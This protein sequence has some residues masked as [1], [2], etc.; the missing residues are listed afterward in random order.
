M[1]TTFTGAQA[2]GFRLRRQHLQPSKQIPRARCPDTV[3][4]ICRDTAGIQAQVMSAAEMSI[5]TR[6]RTITRD[7]IRAALWTR[8][9][10][11]KTSAMRFTLHLVPA[12]DFATYIAA[13]KP[14]AYGIINRVFT[15]LSARPD[16][17]QA[18]IQSVVDA[19]ADGPKTQQE[20][21]AV[22]ARTPSKGVRAWLKLAWSA[23]RPAVV[24]GLVVYGPSKGGEV[25][26]VRTDKWLP[27]QPVIATDDARA[28]LM[29]KFLAAF[30]PATPHDFA[31]W[32]GIPI[33]DAKRVLQSIADDT[34][35]VTVDGAPGW[36]LRHHVD[37]LRESRLD[38]TIR[39]LPAFDTLL[40]AH[41]TKEHI[42][43]L[44]Y[45]K[46]VYRP[47]AWISPVVLAGGRIV[48]VWFP[49]T[50]GKRVEVDVQPFTPLPRRIR[51]AVAE[52][53]AALGAFLGVD[54]QVRFTR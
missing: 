3:V 37:E 35:A 45:Y 24:Q 34:I 5:W 10:V 21:V 18:V 49:K 46:R 54:A 29:R 40:L 38:D 48:A 6:G 26:F 47:Q 2:A 22:A 51:D 9:E 17:V 52:E 28:A 4:D 53:T 13:L 23:V 7:D 14:S 44:K 25:T 30:G 1:K 11:V 31:K 42:V 8:R 12:D 43:D 19:L 20:L 39:L 36:V 33:G 32:S 15:R 27:P 41:A 16:D 50:R